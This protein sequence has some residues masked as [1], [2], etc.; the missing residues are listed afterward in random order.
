L[1]ITRDRNRRRQGLASTLLGALLEVG[2]E[3][4]VEIFVTETS[5]VLDDT[6]FLFK[7]LGFQEAGSLPGFIKDRDGNYNDLIV[8]VRRMSE[9]FEH[10]EMENAGWRLPPVHA[11]V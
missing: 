4:G 5:S 3:R 1:R 2:A 9:T 6:H 8:M 10:E 11:V 7:R